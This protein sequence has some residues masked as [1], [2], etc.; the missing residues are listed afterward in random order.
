MLE[1]VLHGPEGEAWI[2][3]PRKMPEEY[4]DWVDAQIESKEASKHWNT[5]VDLVYPIEK[6]KSKIALD[7]MWQHIKTVS[8]S[9]S[10]YAVR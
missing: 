6:A 7:K 1:S 8:Q 3:E 4:E 2:K 5:F 9:R 10:F